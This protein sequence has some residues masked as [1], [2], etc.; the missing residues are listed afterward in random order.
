MFQDLLCC[1][2]NRKCLS[3]FI[4]TEMEEYM[5]L[6]SILAV[7]LSGIFLTFLSTTGLSAIT[8]YLDAV[9]IVIIF[10]ITIPIL[11]SS[12]LHKDFNHAFSFSFGNKKPSSFLELTKAK[13]AVELV[14]KTV[15]MAGAFCTVGSMIIVFIEIEDVKTLLCNCAVACLTLLYALALDLILLPV[16]Y[17][18]DAKTAEY[19]HSTED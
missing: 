13:A 19:M 1:K 3:A 6:L 2:Y 5:Y 9:S 8:Y 4:S 18:L 11:I 12:G 7:I 16:S 10:I 17:K 14:R 15:L